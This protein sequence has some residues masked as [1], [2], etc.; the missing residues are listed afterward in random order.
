MENSYI[1]IIIN[2][3]ALNQLNQKNINFLIFK[4]LI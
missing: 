1:T 3:T 2:I 4:R